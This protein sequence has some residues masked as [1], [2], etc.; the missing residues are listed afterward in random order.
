MSASPPLNHFCVVPSVF[1]LLVVNIRVV[2]QPS[3]VG[4]SKSKRPEKAV[5]SVGDGAAHNHFIDHGSEKWGLE[6]LQAFMR[7]KIGRG[8][9]R[10]GQGP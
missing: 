4:W 1:L 8:A 7:A 6:V 5:D 3:A 10:E 2:P 9:I